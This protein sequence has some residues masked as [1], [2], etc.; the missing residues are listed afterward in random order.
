MK[1]KE[2]PS[3]EAR[4]NASGRARRQY[5]GCRLVSLWGRAAVPLVHVLV[6]GCHEM[7]LLQ[8]EELRMC[9]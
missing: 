2:R 9:Q 1:C 8:A 3:T 5:N 7:M 4:S 6:N